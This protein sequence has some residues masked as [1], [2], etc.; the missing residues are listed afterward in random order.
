MINI[1]TD[2]RL[3][4]ALELLAERRHMSVSDLIRQTMIA[5]LQKEEIN[6]LE[7]DLSEFD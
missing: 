2:L 3:K 1:R 7:I 4:R 6:W 5:E